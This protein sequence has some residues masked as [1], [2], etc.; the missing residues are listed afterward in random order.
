[1][2]RLIAVKPAGKDVFFQLLLGQSEHLFGR[3]VMLEKHLRYLIYALVRALSRQ[4][5]RNQQLVRR[6]VNQRGHRA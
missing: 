6:A 1:M 4:N 2:L 5:Y 3:V